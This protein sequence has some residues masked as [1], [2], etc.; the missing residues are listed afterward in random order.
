MPSE[1]SGGCL[2]CVV[3]KP[4][5]KSSFVHV[6]MVEISLSLLVQGIEARALCT[7]SKHVYTE[8]D[9]PALWQSLICEFGTVINNR[10]TI[11][12]MVKW[13]NYHHLW[14][15][16]LLIVHELSVCAYLH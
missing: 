4:E 1:T 2:R 11:I 8:L 10:L 9:P 12:L 14:Q 7:S 6:L 3:P 15:G 16:E 13:N 5:Q